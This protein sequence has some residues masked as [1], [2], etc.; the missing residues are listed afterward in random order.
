MV[1]SDNESGHEGSEPAKKRLRTDSTD[2]T[3]NINVLGGSQE[4]EVGGQDG[5]VESH[6]VYSGQE[7]R[8]WIHARPDEVTLRQYHQEDLDTYAY[9]QPAENLLGKVYQL[10]NGRIGQLRWLDETRRHILFAYDA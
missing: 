7:I 3:D 1:D 8:A 4:D 10:K 2:S 9:I 5:G 6:D